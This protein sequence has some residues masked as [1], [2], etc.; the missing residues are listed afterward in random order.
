MN[1]SMNIEQPHRP[2]AIGA[3]FRGG[4][5]GLFSGLVM[6]G[7][8]FL[9]SP[10]ILGTGLSLGGAGLMIAAPTLFGGIMAAKRA[11]FDAP[12]A[13][14]DSA[15]AI[16]PVPVQTISGPVMMPTMAI[17]DEA[18]APAPTKNW[19]A[20]TG[21]GKGANDRI[22]QILADGSLSDKDR[23]SAI[24]ASREAADQH[25]SRA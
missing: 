19:V 22:Q 24:L 11:I 9:I 1:E 13:H 15:T 17:A 25:A 8:I 5:S 2:S 18:P 6:A 7:V 4:I 21:R 12:H 16:V 3:F 10:F 14:H 23:A 20:E